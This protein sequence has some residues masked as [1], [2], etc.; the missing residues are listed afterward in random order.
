MS[1]A[2]GGCYRRP[3]D[4][5]IETDSPGA[6]EDAA[7]ALAG[8]LVPG[9]VLAL[10]G[11]L[12]AGKTHFTRGLVRGLG[13]EVRQV[14]SP[15]YTLLQIYDTPRGPVFHLDAYRTA[16]ADD[17]DAIGFGELLGE[18]GFVVVEWAAKIADLLPAGV[19]RVRLEATGKRARQI[20]IAG[21]A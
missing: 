15:T 19:I 20:T 14:S 7:A 16:G 10:D 21:R 13:G 2:G 4:R 17:L 11:D 3:V 12:G 5:V 1:G 9:D 6:T 8:E 18:G